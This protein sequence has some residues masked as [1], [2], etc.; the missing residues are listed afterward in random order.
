MD[1]PVHI[2]AAA[3]TCQAALA[4]DHHTSDSEHPRIRTGIFGAGYFALGAL[5][6]LFLDAIPHYDVLYKIGRALRP[7][8]LP[9]FIWDVMK[10]S[11]FFGIFCLP[12]IMLFLYFTREYPV[13]ALAAL[14]GGLYP[15]FEKGGYLCSSLPRSL[16][17]FPFHSCGYSS[18]GWEVEYRYALIAAEAVLLAGL[19]GLMFWLG[20][21]QRVPSA[22]PNSSF[23]A[24]YKEIVVSFIPLASTMLNKILCKFSQKIRILSKRSAFPCKE[25]SENFQELR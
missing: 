7:D 2:A 14:A 4:L 24:W 13:F 19:L 18:A 6:H 20:Q 5:S 10:I 17:L 25:I 22:G 23:T 12:I 11:V 9:E 1:I 21:K 8:F 15:D 16:V 3:V